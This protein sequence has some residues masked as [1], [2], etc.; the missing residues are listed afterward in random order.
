MKKITLGIMLL[1]VTALSF[2]SCE[3]CTTCTALAGTISQEYCGKSADVE[4]FEAAWETTY[5]LVGDASCTRD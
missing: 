5:A 2:S 1:A 3:K 4:D